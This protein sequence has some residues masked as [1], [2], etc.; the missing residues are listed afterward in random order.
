MIWP[1]PKS[2]PGD[3]SSTPSR[4]RS[5]AAARVYGVDLLRGF[6]ALVVLAYHVALESGFT[7]Q[8]L[9]DGTLAKAGIYGVEAFFVVSGFSLYVASERLDF[10]KINDVRNFLIRR[11]VRILPLLF[12]ATIATV[13]VIYGLDGTVDPLRLIGNFAVVPIIIDPTLALARGA[14]SLGVEWGFYLAFPLLM[15]ARQYL[16]VA[17]FASVAVLGIYSGLMQTHDLASQNFAYVSIPN[18]LAFFIAGMALARWRI[19]EMGTPLML[20]CCLIIAAA[21]V[22][23]HPQIGDQAEVA[24]GW[25][26]LVFFTL[27]V[28]IVGIFSAWKGGQSIWM[29]WLGDISFALYL[30]H[31]LA[32]GVSA[33]VL[34]D[35]GV[36]A[37]IALAL[38]LTLASVSY[39][40]FERPILAW[41][42]RLTGSKA[43]PLEKTTW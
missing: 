29:R 16:A 20:G 33:R 17:L 3:V 31:P 41:G 27:C 36:A 35:G 40:A 34:G 19:P 12:A 43:A 8:A 2:D 18:H 22:G 13:V 37:V 26:R 39:Y 30:I 5:G 32:Y 6:C 38:S 1:P 11:A 9:I 10:R 23:F 15:I 24:A 4:T 14:W 7:G 28:A 21:F 25:L 42:K